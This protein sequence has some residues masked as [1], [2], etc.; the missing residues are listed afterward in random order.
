MHKYSGVVLDYYDDK[1]AT[2][3]ALFPTAEALPD[4]IKTGSIQPLESLPDEAFALVALDEGHVLKKFACVDE[5][6]TAMS[7]IYFLQHG[8]K[9]PEDAVKAAAENLVYACL[10]NGLVPPVPL[11]KKAG[12]VRSG[13]ERVGG[14][15]KNWRARRAAGGTVPGRY[16]D[17]TLKQSGKSFRGEIG[18]TGKQVEKIV[19]DLGSMGRG[20]IDKFKGQFGGYASGAVKRVAT[21]AATGTATGAAGGATQGDTVGG[22]R[23]GLIA[24]AIG[25]GA[26]RAF[27]RRAGPAAG[28][29]ILG[30]AGGALFGRDK[31]PVDISG[32]EAKPKVMKKAA[33]H[34]ALQL[35]D[36]RQNF[37]IDSWD[38]VKQAE[39]YW[40]ENNKLMDPPIRREYAVKLASRAKEMCCPLNQDISF[41]GSSTFGPSGHVKVAMEYRKLVSSD[42]GE[43]LDELFEKRADLG[44][45]LFS[46]VLRKFDTEN[47][48]DT[49]WSSRVPDPWSS[50][51]G[52]DKTAGYVWEDAADRVSEEQL[53]NLAINKKELL[54]KTFTED[55]TSGFCKNPVSVFKSMPLPEKR[56]LSRM[57]ADSAS[58]GGSEGI[59]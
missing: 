37:P 8:S 40:L 59:G 29:A 3:K 42:H 38:Q 52:I 23:R 34:Y 4:A 31:K 1:G 45:E 6:T 12:K 50:T 44:P 18:Q 30:G 5:G 26:G 7:T 19:E 43:F 33:E 15:I 47:G 41:R 35:P 17:K 36:G 49:L 27:S 28:G 54:K 22:A 25:G 48:L 20:E 11:L 24:G 39:V 32:Q 2:L 51:F 57:A 55:M 16:V 10:D 46:E 13:L 14:A 21:G 56:I 58:D 9:L 53:R